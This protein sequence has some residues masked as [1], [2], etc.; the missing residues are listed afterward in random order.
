VKP[1]IRP[2]ALQYLGGSNPPVTEVP[3]PEP[4]E[5]QT[6]RERLLAA[7]KSLIAR[8]GYEQTPAAA[9]AREAGTSESQLNRSFGGK[10]GLLEA[11]FNDAWGSV[12]LR[13]GDQTSGPARKTILAVFEIIMEMFGRDHDIAMLFLF[14][15]HRLRGNEIAIS[16]GFMQFYQLIQ[17]I[18]R[19]GQK[20]GSFRSDLDPTVLAAALLGA[21]EGMMR[22]RLLA[23]RRGGPIPF[24]DAA[25][26]ATF[27][28]MIDG[29]K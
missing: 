5:K 14:E 16:N 23:E 12:L 15:G 4:A 19:R 10:A 21:A 28:A 9:I 20:D 24:D 22:D 18:V 7:G 27:R 25:L 26:R 1:L 3:S 8:L 2:A 17:S 29:L 13:L 11:I 6:S